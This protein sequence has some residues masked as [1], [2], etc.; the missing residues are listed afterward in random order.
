MDAKKNSKRKADG[1]RKPVNSARSQ[2]AVPLSVPDKIPEKIIVPKKE[3]YTALPPAMP[4]KTVSLEQSGGSIISLKNPVVI[5][6]EQSFKSQDASFKTEIIPHRQSLLHLLRHRNVLTIC[7]GLGITL[8]TAILLSTVFARV[9]VTVKPAVES[10]QVQNIEIFFNASASEVNAETRTLP[11]EFLSFDGSVSEDFDA[12]GNDYVSQKA[13]GRVKIYNAFNVNPQALVATTRFIADSGILFR[14][15]KAITIPAAKKDAQGNIVPQFIETDLIA[16]QP[17]EGSNIEGEVKLRILGFKGSSKYDGFYAVSQTGFSG[18]GI[19]QGRVITH[20]DLTAAQQ[21]VSKKVFDDLKQSM[22]QK[23]PAPFKLVES[24][25]EITIKTIDAPK[26]KTKTNRFT[27]SAKAVARVFVFRD[28]DII[29]LLNELLLKGDSTK[30]FIDASANFHYQI[31][32][33][34]YDKKNAAVTINGAI[35]TKKVVSV[36]DLTNLIAGKKEG[37][38]IDALNK[39]RDIGTFRVAFFPPWIFSAPTNARQIHVFIEDVGAD[40]K[41]AR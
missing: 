23:I 30:A 4:E 37:S 26:E 22:A 13:I 19:G 28:A 36:Q 5:N 9:S 39:R 25:S 10:F 11:S 8:V 6:Q 16:D 27:V 38:L 2:N 7:A 33:A 21:R 24:L 17:G 29:R 3:I 40:A 1:I 35:K 12:T 34:N 31:K 32:N 15:P 18:G 20:D 41:T 14:L